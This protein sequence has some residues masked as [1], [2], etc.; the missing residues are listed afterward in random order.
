MFTDIDKNKEV[1]K[2][3]VIG[4]GGGGSR[5]VNHMVDSGVTGVEFAAVDTDKQD[6][7]SSKAQ[8]KIQIGEQLTHGCGTD[9]VDPEVGRKAA[10]E[11]R[12]QITKALEGVNMVFIIAGMGGG[13]GTGAAPVVAGAAKEQGILTVGVVTMP[14]GFEGR[15]R[16]TQAEAGI[17]EL[18]GKVDSLIIISD[19]HLKHA[20]KQKITFANAFAISDDMLRQ[21]VLSVTDLLQ[22]KGFI[23]LDFDGVA[24]IMKDAG[25][26]HVGVG[27]ADWVSDKGKEA[28]WRAISSPLLETSING[29]R[30]I[31]IN[32][33]GPKDM[34]FDDANDAAVLL[35]AFAH[36]DANIIFGAAIDESLDDEIRVT[37]IATGFDWKNV[38]RGPQESSG[39]VSG[40]GGEKKEAEA[41]EEKKEASDTDGFFSEPMW[42]FFSA[43]LSV[44]MEENLK[45]RFDAVC[46]EAG[47]DASIAVKLFVETVV[48]EKRILFEISHRPFLFWS[49]ANQA[50]QGRSA[51]QLDAG[52][53]DR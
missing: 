47:M 23:N 50:A 13:T 21:T 3:K 31:L 45:R 39:T 29:A 32:I 11:S 36:P 9:N 37:V 35:Q 34:N 1:I 48:R 24:A 10:E 46:A 4:V 28:A 18:R 22:N 43:E 20:T 53:E 42:D 17:E 30:G 26:A 49:E 15:R 27:W 33:T 6:L 14:F 51:A 19:D 7:D 38:A 52:K 8:D 41:S 25:L 40:S 12:G 16:R 5:V 44:R 2:I